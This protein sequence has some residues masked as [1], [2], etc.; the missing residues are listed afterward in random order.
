MSPEKRM[1]PS[2]ISG[3]FASLRAA[4]TLATAEICGTPTPATMR[5]VQIEPGPM[6][7]LTASA[8]ASTSARAA[9]AVAM[10]PAITWLSAQRALIRFTVSMTPF[11]CPCAVST[12]TRSTPASRSAATRSSV[13]GV[14]P[15]AVVLAGAREFLGLL[16]ILHGD[17]ADQLMRTADYQQLLDAVLV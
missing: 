6:P 8:P 14:V 7:T 15:P 10:L 5:V 4:A 2:E 13:S 12:T 16:E 17:H 11:E 9:S 1:P 3:T